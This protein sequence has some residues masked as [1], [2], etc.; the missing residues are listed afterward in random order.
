MVSAIQG[1]IPMSVIKLSDLDRDLL[2]STEEYYGIRERAVAQFAKTGR[3]LQQD[4]AI[5]LYVYGYTTIFRADSLDIRTR[6]YIDHK[7]FDTWLSGKGFKVV[8]HLRL[9]A[10]LARLEELKQKRMVE[11]AEL[12]AIH[13]TFGGIKRDTDRPYVVLPK[14]GYKLDLPSY[15]GFNRLA[16]ARDGWMRMVGHSLS[17]EIQDEIVDRLL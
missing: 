16:G 15:L 11:N 10:M 14:T 9:P 7:Q 17:S 13:V 1:A 8:K 5:A 4:V 6:V 2:L 3:G 12:E